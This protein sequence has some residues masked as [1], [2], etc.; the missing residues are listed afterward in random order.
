M[1]KRMGLRSLVVLALVFLLGINL[2]AQAED[3]GTTRNVMLIVDA[4]GSMKKAVDGEAR[5]TA[6]KRVLAETLATMPPEVR[7]GLLAYGHRKA[8]DCK[9]M[10][11]VSPIGAEDA[12]TI[13]GRIQELNPKGETPIAAS[14]EMAAKSFLAFKGQENSIVLVT[15]GIEECK[16]DPCAAAAAIKAAGLDLKVNVVGFTLKPEQRKLIECVATETGGT[17]YDAK[18]GAALSTALASVAKAATKPK[19]PADDILAA[20][21]GGVLIAAANDDWLK[22]NDGKEDDRAVTYNTT[23]IYG[24]KEGKPATITGVD[25]LIPEQSEYNVKDFEVFV[26]DESPTGSF[27]SVGTFTTQNIKLMQDPYQR[28]T[29]PPVKA[30]YIK[31][32]F[33]TDWGGGYIAAY[34]L[35]AHGKIDESAPASDPKPAAATGIDLLAPQNGGTILAAPNDDWA[36]LNNG[37]AER[38][39]PYAGEGVWG[40]RDGKPATFDRFEM[41]IPMTDQYNVKEFELFAGD[42]SP[43]GSFRSIGSFTTENI[44]FMLAPYQAFTFPAVTAKYLKVALKTDWGGGYIAADDFRLF[45]QLADEGA[46]ASTAQTASTSAPTGSDANLLAQANGGTILTAPNDEWAKLNDGSEDRAVTYDGEGVWQFK[47]GQPATF[48][49][50]EMLIPAQDGYNVKAFELL[51]GD[52]GPSGSF[53]SI[54]T[55][56][57]QNIKLMQSP[58][59]KFTFAPVT[60]K[61]LKV[62]LKSDWGG[63]YIAAYEFRLLNSA[64]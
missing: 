60:A 16:G 29:F 35:R 21:N 63:G 7:L 23:G 24:F 55:F 31:F 62:I 5:M 46:A 32:A 40:F 22:L 3:D 59:Q 49:T 64:R 11:L 18:N 52:E 20:K 12:G 28:F 37:V 33:N 54:G 44:K 39:V 47:D 1:T 34:E 57:T 9:D 26:G 41:L 15:D 53:R 36:K 42:E 56:T 19:A 8:K 27:K 61:Y 50:F 48:D 43:T 4:S 17:Y 45:G 30:K 51:A 6:A 58:Y 13:A 10:E 2:S 25:L 38:A 14:L